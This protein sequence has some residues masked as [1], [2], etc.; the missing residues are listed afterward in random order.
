MIMWDR[1][2]RG[3]NPAGLD[4]IL[5]KRRQERRFQLDES[6]QFWY[7]T[8]LNYLRPENKENI[9]FLPGM[10]RK[11]FEICQSFYPRD[12][13]EQSE[14]I[15]KGSGGENTILFFACPLWS[16]GSIAVVQLLS[17]LVIILNFN[18]Y[19]LYIFPKT[20]YRK[21][22]D[23]YCGDPRKKEQI[24]PRRVLECRKGKTKPLSS[25]PPPYSNY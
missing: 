8:Q 13:K 7:F 25:F 22:W 24:K 10:A 23:T 21:S 4:S 6:L 20:S 11:S 1:R 15:C 19:I 5:A 9:P 18:I 12:R 3:I 16:L 17:T 14:R 2:S